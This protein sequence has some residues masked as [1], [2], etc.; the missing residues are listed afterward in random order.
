MK[1]YLKTHTGTLSLQSTLKEINSSGA[2]WDIYYKGYITKRIENVRI[3]LSY[4][5]TSLEEPSMV[6]YI[7]H[8]DPF[9]WICT[10]ALADQIFRLDGAFQEFL[11]FILHD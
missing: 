1:Q 8:A 3:F 7:F 5:A 10:Y 2:R 11:P 9:N 4:G 6:Q